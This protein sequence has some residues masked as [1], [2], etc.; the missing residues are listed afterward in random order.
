MMMKRGLVVVGIVWAIVAFEWEDR[1]QRGLFRYDVTA[2]ETKVSSGQ[3]GIEHVSCST[4]YFNFS[5]METW[6]QPKFLLLISVQVI[7]GDY[8]F[9]AQ[10]NEGR[11]LKKQP[12]EFLSLPLISFLR[13]LLSSKTSS[14]I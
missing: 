1:M 12:T 5:S 7:A 3:V 14:F 11:H 2:C 13:S 9:V 10:L 6:V 8:G 4:E